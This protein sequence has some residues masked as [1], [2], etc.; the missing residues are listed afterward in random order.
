MGRYIDRE[1]GGHVQKVHTIERVERV[2][3]KSQEID[4]EKLANAVA[5]AIEDK[6]SDMRIKSATKETVIVAVKDTFDETKNVTA[7]K[8]I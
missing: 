3:E 7:I 4:F 5:H 6:F 1:T 8:V 2:V